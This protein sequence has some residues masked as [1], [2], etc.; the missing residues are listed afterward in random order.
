MAE[1]QLN[2]TVEEVNAILSK[3]ENGEVLTSAEKL[4][5]QTL[6]L[7]N[8]ATL[9]YVNNTIETVKNS[10]NNNTNTGGGGNITIQGSNN[11]ISVKNFGAKGDGSTDDTSAIQSAFNAAKSG[12]VVI[13]FPFG[14]YKIKN[15]ITLTD[16]YN[17]TIEGNSS[18][19]QLYNDSSTK[20][21]TVFEITSLNNN[22]FKVNDLI[23]D[24][25]NTPQDLFS[26]TN[27][28]SSP[29]ITAY[30]IDSDYIS[31]N[32]CTVKNIYGNGI[33]IQNYKNVVI[34]DTYFDSVG[35]HWYKNDTYDCF[36]DAIYLGDRVNARVTIENVVAV[37]KKSGNTLSRIGITVED[38]SNADEEIFI[39]V[40]NSRFINFD[41]VVHSELNNGT[42]QLQFDQCE[43]HGNVIL[44]SWSDTT[45]PCANLYNCNISF[46][47]QE[48]NG[49]KGLSYGFDKCFFTD[50][51][52]DCSGRTR[53]F[54]MNGPNLVF[55]N[56]DI[57]NIA[58]TLQEYGSVKCMN[59]RLTLSTSLTEYLFY[60]STSRKFEFE[61]C[62]ISSSGSVS[63][64]SGGT[65]PYFYNCKFSG[66]S[67]S[68]LGSTYTLNCWD[69]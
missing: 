12:D 38:F 48:Y 30:E 5:L 59:S 39:T 31:L 62:T 24:G 65:K 68:S 44:F 63:L 34:K 25:S 42:V 37:G 6:N 54:G 66:V 61:N 41:R 60:G 19:L 32:N 9:D 36:G 56:C 53:A 64:N 20:G 52:I 43:L 57:T 3:V 22:F 16:A 13:F 1:K 8:Y 47:N 58:Y 51:K 40:K 14:T 67:A 69:I 10:I 2:Y 45:R 15:G 50:C 35:G 7:S 4:K 33:K 28:S 18:T 17:I 23:I 11:W 26:A 21:Y 27:F 49:S 46:F 29:R 55:N